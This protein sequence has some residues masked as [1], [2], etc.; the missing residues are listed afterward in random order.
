MD[1]IEVLESTNFKVEELIDI[2]AKNNQGEQIK[3]NKKKAIYRPDL[4]KVVTITSPQYTVLKHNQGIEA[5]FNAFDSHDIAYDI[6]KLI[7]PSDGNRMFLHLRHPKQYTIG[8]LDDKVQM[9]TIVTNSLDGS[10]PFGMELGCYRL[11]CKNGMRAWRKDFAVRRRH[12]VFNPQEVVEQYM[13]QHKRFEKEFLPFFNL[14]TQSKISRQKGLELISALSIA[15]KYQKLATQLWY[16][17]D[18]QTGKTLWTLYNC[19]TRIATHVVKS[20]MVQRDLEM[21]AFQVVR[22]RLSL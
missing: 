20:Y 21:K 4:D 15:K 19:C 5:V 10:L 7:L 8:D 1:K 11:I 2:Y 6:S 22:E 18:E 13:I 17:D 3:I 9:E 12:Y 16:K 14:C